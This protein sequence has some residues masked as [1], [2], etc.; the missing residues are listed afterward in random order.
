VARNAQSADILATDAPLDGLPPVEIW[1]AVNRIGG[2]RTLKGCTKLMRLLAFV[3][4]ATLEGEADYL[5]ETV[6]GVFVFG[7]QPDFDP[8]VDTIVR[9][10]AWRLRAKLKK[11]YAYEGSQDHVIIDLPRGHY[12][13]VFRGPQIIRD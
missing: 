3:V 6:I 13:P 1:A 12:V 2:S 8:K 9:S 10:Q 4:K 5:K 11:Y 7:R